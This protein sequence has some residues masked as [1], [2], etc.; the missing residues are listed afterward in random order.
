MRI[1]L[2]DVDGHNYPNLALMKISAYHKARGDHV[3]WYSPLLSG[4]MDKVY[5][6]K[7]FSFS[8]DY[9]HFIDADEVIKGGTGYCI[10][11]ENG[12]EVYHKE[13]EVNLPPEIEHTCP[14]YSVY[15]I[16]GVAYGY[17]S[18]GCP[19]GCD[20]CH[21]QAKEGCR[22]RKVADLG[23]WWTGEKKIVLMDPNILACSRRED[24]LQQLAESKAWV[25]INQGLDARMVTPQRIDLLNEIKL[26]NVH[27]AW[28][29]IEDEAP[30]VKGLQMWADLSRRKFNGHHG[31]V[32]ILV[33]HGTT[34]EQDLHRIYKVKELGFDPYVMPYDKEHAPKEIMR[35]RRWCNSRRIIAVCPRFEDYKGGKN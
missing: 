27:F 12:V 16:T 6:S 1:G 2:I 34:I 10:E 28:D 18:R 30:V 17:T 35:L 24:L 13:R 11:L 5:M 23:E 19:R 14:D 26:E 7:V 31:T 8:E 32:Y 33:N 21:V 9:R 20:F 3:E 4:H 15:G 25:D 22:S 29:R